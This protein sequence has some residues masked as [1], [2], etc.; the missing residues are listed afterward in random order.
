MHTGG[1]ASLFYYNLL[2]INNIYN[3]RREK[4]KSRMPFE[5]KLKTETETNQRKKTNSLII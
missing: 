2:I 4:S 3:I 1:T 5:N